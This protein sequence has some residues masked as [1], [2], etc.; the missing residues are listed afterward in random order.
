MRDFIFWSLATA[1]TL[2]QTVQ[3]LELVK[4]STPAVVGFEFER[5]KVVNPIEHDK[6]RRK[7][8]NKPKVV[9]Q[10]LDNQKTLYFSNLTLGTPPQKLQMHIDTGSSD[11]WVNTPSSKLCSDSRNLCAIGGTYD[12]KKSSTY[13]LI[14]SDFNITYADGSGAVGDYVSDTMSIAGATL[15]ELQFA[16]GYQSTS[17]EGV[18]GIGFAQN[19]VQSVRNNVEPYANLPQALVDNGL[20]RSNAYSIWLN[21][22]DSNKGEILFGGVNTAKFQGALKTV[23]V[24]PRRG[25]YRDLSVALTGL[26]VKSSAGLQ[27]FPAGNFP[28][29]V[30]LDTGSSLTYLPNVIV[31]EIFSAVSAVWDSNAGAAYVPCDLAKSDA[32]FIFTFSEPNITVGMDEMVV[33][34]GPNSRGQRLRFDDGTPACIFGIVP[35]ENS[36]AILGDT[37]I[38]SAYVVYDL[39]NREISLAQ[40][41]FNSTNDDILEIGTGRNSVPDATGVAG[42]VSTVAATPSAT[43][44]TTL[45]AIATSNGGN[46]RP[47][48]SKAGAIPTPKPEYP[49]GMIAGLAGAGMVFAAM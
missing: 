8:Q 44:Q 20:I 36:V 17:R 25:A 39:N 28:F 47:V 31:T 40:T 37:F 21:D 10:V 11:L 23:P 24:V 5:R 49:L 6:Q 34:P 2:L 18:L 19:E 13:K 43:V 35:A 22:L 38:R 1:A 4:R 30:V 48:S 16:V 7:R 27:R 33:D 9:N 26:A 46:V 15:K 3:G 29:S 41:K 45:T 12:P 32:Q 42:A 14:T